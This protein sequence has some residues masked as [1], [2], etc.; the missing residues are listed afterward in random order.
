MWYVGARLY[1]RPGAVQTLEAGLTKENKTKQNGT[2]TKQQDKDQE[3]VGTPVSLIR[4]SQSKLLAF[5]P[6]SPYTTYN[7][8]VSTPDTMDPDRC[9]YSNAPCFSLMNR[10]PAQWEGC[11]P[12]LENPQKIQKLLAFKCE[13]TQEEHVK[14]SL[15]T[16]MLELWEVMF[17][18]TLRFHFLPRRRSH[19]EGN[20]NTWA[21]NALLL[22]EEPKDG[23]VCMKL[24]AL[25]A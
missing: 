6:P 8:P 7:H 16:T 4:A 10:S 15:F 9:S 25:M 24:T 14:H 18:V 3:V 1:Y 12:D 19:A 22:H 23:Q 17:Q 5:T 13:P 2:E 11:S 20:V 21:S